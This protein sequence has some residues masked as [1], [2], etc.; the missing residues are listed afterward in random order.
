M[1]GVL[2]KAALS[3]TERHVCLDPT[4]APSG[5][6]RLSR[7]APTG[8]L[9]ESGTVLVKTAPSGPHRVLSRTAPHGPARLPGLAACLLTGPVRLPGLSAYRAYPLVLSW[10]AE[11]C[12]AN[13]PTTKN[14]WPIP[15]SQLETSAQALS[16]HWETVLSVVPLPSSWRT[17]E[18]KS[19]RQRRYA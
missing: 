12:S 6:G 19:L 3:W 11:L 14:Q 17:S 9:G 5:L 1:S 13:P 8:R 16:S 7:T 4:T 2:D 10:D 15:I 18:S